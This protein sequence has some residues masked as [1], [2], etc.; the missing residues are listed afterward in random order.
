MLL[1]VDGDLK[2]QSSKTLKSA[3]K[4]RPF[5]VKWGLG[6][7][8]ALLFFD[9]EESGITDF[10]VCTREPRSRSVI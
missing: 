2:V 7:M 3:V 4:L 6:K 5:G 1:K 10:N 9:T 8:F